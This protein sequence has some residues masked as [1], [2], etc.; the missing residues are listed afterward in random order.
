MW[1]L[2]ELFFA[3]QFILRV[4]PGVIMSDIMQKFHINATSFGIL[5]AFYYI[6]YAGMQVP[7]GVLLDRYG[8]KKIVGICAL[9]CVLGNLTF[10]F[11]N[12]WL[13]A[14]LGRFLIGFGST[15]GFLG[16]TK[17]VSL[18]FKP[19]H[20]AYMMSATFVIGYLG[21]IVGAKPV[22]LMVDQFGSEN[23]LII[24]SA[25]GLLI[26]GAIFSLTTIKYSYQTQ[27]DNIMQQI[28][29]VLK[30]PQIILICACGALQVG[31]LEAFADIWGINYFSYVHGIE[32]V[33][34][35]FL[36]SAIYAG[37]CVGGPIIAHYADKYL[38]HHSL[39]AI[40]GVFMVAIF[41]ILLA[42]IKPSYN[43]LLAMMFFLGMFSSYQILVFVITCRIAP[44]N[45]TGVVTSVTNMI[46]MSAGSFFH[47][48]IGYVMD[49]FWNGKIE[50]QVHIYNAEAYTNSLYILPITLVMGAIGFI[51]LRPKAGQDKYYA[52]PSAS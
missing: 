46:V 23:V 31:P 24:F 47:F 15:A 13:I 33:D 44:S 51:I 2:A 1:L 30:N 40:C 42:G 49:L 5:S 21:A 41:A 28:L 43:E 36:T 27:S 19:K 3:Y 39:C 29:R 11:S 8:P 22:A 6:G 12:H 20:F 48:V 37:L 18:W 32:K 9:I 50:N 38:I 7:V 14:L 25:V 16:S 52:D 45:L 34:S 4:A 26:A 35:A 17:A 10:V